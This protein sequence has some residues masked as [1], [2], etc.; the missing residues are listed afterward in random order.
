MISQTES[1]IKNLGILSNDINSLISEDEIS[2]CVT[3]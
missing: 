2:S 1:G 3:S